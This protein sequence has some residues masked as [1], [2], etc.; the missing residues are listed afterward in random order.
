VR[1]S[2][3][4][5]P[6]NPELMAVPHSTQARLV[7]R[8]HEGRYPHTCYWIGTF[9][10]RFRRKRPRNHSMRMAGLPV[11]SMKPAPLSADSSEE[12]RGYLSGMLD[13]TSILNGSI[14]A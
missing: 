4:P 11:P 3:E 14:S 10:G 9:A 12:E 5:D 8:G 7:S 6:K 13:G 2:R 1:L